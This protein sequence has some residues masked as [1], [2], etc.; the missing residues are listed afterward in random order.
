MA[1]EAA[2]R[3]KEEKAAGE[4]RSKAEEAEAVAARADMEQVRTHSDAMVNAARASADA[5]VERANG[6]EEE[7]RKAKRAV[8]ALEST[9]S[10]LD[11]KLRAAKERVATLSSDLE[12]ARNSSPAGALRSSSSVSL[13][14]ASEAQQQTPSEAKP[15]SSYWVNLEG[16][17]YGDCVCGFPKAK[18]AE[19]RRLSPDST[20]SKRLS[21]QSP[22]PADVGRQLEDARR[23]G[24][25]AREE[26]KAARAD[27]ARERKRADGADATIKDVKRQCDKLATKLHEANAKNKSLSDKLSSLATSAPSIDPVNDGLT[28]DPVSLRPDVMA[29]VWNWKMVATH[30]CFSYDFGR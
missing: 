28:I 16:A 7:T 29:K 26:T 13:A 6:A 25:S 18:H 24:E 20:F 5:A 10:E 8:K 14:R 30:E 15:C 27:A 3:E 1:S 22:V 2:A 11:E 17:S 23:D 19:T 9:C 12:A 4:A 21:T